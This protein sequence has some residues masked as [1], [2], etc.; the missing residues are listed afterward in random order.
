MDIRNKRIWQQASGDT[1]RNYSEL[2]LKWGVIL[3]GPGYAGKW[4][5]CQNLLQDEEWSARKITDLR[6][7]CET[8]QIGDLVVLRLGT[9]SVLAVGEIAGEYEWRE[10]F[11]DVDGWDLQHCRR[12][13]WL[14]KAAGD[15]VSFETYALKFGDT[16][17]LLDS[18]EVEAW[19]GALVVPDEAFHAPLPEIPQ[20]ELLSRID[21]EMRDISEYLYDKGLSSVSI[22][23]LVEDIGELTRIAKWYKKQEMRPSEHETVAYLVIPLLRSLGWTPQKMAVEWNRVD[24]ALFADLPR[25]NDN[26][27]VVVEVKKLNNSCLMAKSQAQDYA[28]DRPNCRRLIVTDGLR[29]G[30]YSKNELGDFYLDAYL[31]LTRLQSMYP[32]YDCDGAM[33]SFLLMS[34]ESNFKNGS[35]S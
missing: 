25:G 30:V 23:R 24:V 35:K 10:E 6:R 7:F 19:L 4:P 3:N 33:E 13:R 2:C 8:M 17:Q 22:N 31:N 12:V 20:T 21:L 29:Y 5:E 26:L 11:G 16:T 18:P 28:L 15:P 34:P 1:D 27:T 9:A 32:I 14:W